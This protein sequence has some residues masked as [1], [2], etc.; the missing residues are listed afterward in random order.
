MVMSRV[1]H[2]VALCLALSLPSALPLRPAHAQGGD[3]DSPP[4]QPSTT[5]PQPSGTAPQPEAAQAETVQ[6]EPAAPQPSE[7]ERKALAD[8]PGL[9]SK[10]QYDPLI[11]S[12]TPLLESPAPEAKWPATYWMA[13]Y[14]HQVRDYGRA[15]P[16]LQR[17]ADSYSPLA[18]EGLYW[19]GQC[20]IG[21]GRYESARRCFSAALDSAK[22]DF[23]D[24]CLYQVAYTFY[25][26]RRYETAVKRLDSFLEKYPKSPL[27]ASATKTR[28]TAED[29]LAVA[30]R[31]D[32]NWV[33]N[34][35]LNSVSQRIR[36]DE[37]LQFGLGAN[38]RAG[39]QLA[40]EPKDGMRMSASGF[41]THTAY[42]TSDVVDRSA[43]SAGLSVTHDLGDTHYASYGVSVSTS[44]SMGVVN[45]ESTT[46]GLWGSY[47]F[48]IR[49]SERLSLA[50]NISDLHY[51][52][53]ASSGTS[54]TLSVSYSRPLSRMLS[55]SLGGSYTDSRV[56]ADYLSYRSPT[57]TTGLSQRLNTKGTVR[58]GFSYAGRH[59]AA[60]APRASEIRIDDSRRVYCEY[61]HQLTSKVAVTVG[62]QQTS[63]TSI[64]PSI[65]K[66]E[67]NWYVGVSNL[68]GLTF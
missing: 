4:A 28:T 21:R 12:L 41:A 44:R 22:E 5:A 7:V 13:R 26:E 47:S 65:N 60:L 9:L 49:T 14:Y 50:L 27:A 19:L 39:L 25:L 3:K 18:A 53:V 29:R 32:L 61:A 56:G 43:R 30:R 40:W 16:M 64:V 35:G 62:W 24:D 59:F 52:S 42:L 1:V 2:V 66:T 68:L 17:V 38:G 10:K 46:T 57:L 55:M 36:W 48:P 11:Q 8:A 6:A 20:W 15:M 63:G 33:A 58:A 67:G 54:Q 23:A 51:A 37:E 31:V 34:I 45:G